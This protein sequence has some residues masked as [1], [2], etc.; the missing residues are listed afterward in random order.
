MKANVT[1]IILNV[2]R[3]HLE[4]NELTPTILPRAVLVCVMA[5]IEGLKHLR[6]HYSSSLKACNIATK[7]LQEERTGFMKRRFVTLQRESKIRTPCLVAVNEDTYLHCRLKHSFERGQ[8]YNV[9]RRDATTVIHL[10]L[11][12]AGVLPFHC[13]IQN[14]NDVLF[15]KAEGKVVVNHQQ[16]YDTPLNHKDLVVMVNL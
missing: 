2:L 13:T 9:G 4:A 10:K 14:D 5:K 8:T 11:G 6:S 7:L 3:Q 1:S 12:G 16:E 15:L